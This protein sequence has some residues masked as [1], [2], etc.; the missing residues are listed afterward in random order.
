MSVYVGID[1][2]AST[3]KVAA[4]RASYRK[5]TLVGFGA[6]EVP[7]G[8][9]DA[10]RA[11]LVKEAVRAVLGEKGGLGDAL[12]IAAEGAKSAVVTVDLPAN[13]QKA[14]GDVLPFELEPVI[15][16]D[17]SEA[18]FDYR[19]LA[20][21]VSGEKGVTFPVLAAVARTADV[22][23]RIDFVKAALGSEPE[24]VGVGAFPLANLVSV[25]PALAGEAPILLLDLGPRSTDLV[26]LEKGEPVFARTLSYGTQ[27]LPQ[28][29]PKM[30]REVR[31][32]LLAHRAAGGKAPTRTFLSGA[33]VG[34]ADVFFS[35]ELGLPIERLPASTLEPE[36]PNHPEAADPAKYAKAL[37]LAIGLGPKPMGLNLRKGP[38]AY[39]RGF[40]WVKEKVPLLAGLGAAIF[41]TSILSVS[42]DLYSISRERKALEGALGVV[43]KD[44]L[45]ESTES[46][47]R[48]QELLGKLTTVAD[49]DPMPH[50]DAFDVM[51]KLAENIP[52]SMV[53]DIE[54]L[55]VQK[56]HVIV[57]GVVGSIPDAQGIMTALK[58]EHCFSDVKISRTNQVV[59][60]ERQKYVMEFDLKCPEDQKSVAGK[61]PSGA[62]SSSPAGSASAGG[63]K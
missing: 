45:G 49:E 20:A 16:F 63:G 19:M 60:G 7:E 5:T 14:I 23:A 41:V 2:E 36:V 31:A 39:E 9:T 55:D 46:A 11:E 17:M 50:A 13:A 32:S 10:Q 38:L 25:T 35:G 44:V 3:V 61:K 12:A 51:L 37:G 58:N 54:E 15:P 56:G 43:T 1:I 22:R 6:R 18:V 33:P 57:H 40:A 26:V 42:A 29:A 8:A 27:G 52:Q 62:S 53:H 4:I 34:G 59:G 30:A 47:E 24:R 21:P 28:T 48:A